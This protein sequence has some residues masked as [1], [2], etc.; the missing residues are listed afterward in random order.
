VLDLQ[1]RPV[2]LL[3]R[4]RPLDEQPALIGFELLDAKLRGL[5]DATP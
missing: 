2:G 5:E 4:V 1:G 3:G